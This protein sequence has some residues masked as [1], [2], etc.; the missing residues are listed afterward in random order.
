MEFPPHQNPQNPAIAAVAK[1]AGHVFS[2][3]AIETA[4]IC[5][6]ESTNPVTSS[7]FMTT[8]TSFF[9]P[10][11][12]QSGSGLKY[13]DPPS[14]HPPL[15]PCSSPF[16]ASFLPWDPFPGLEMPQPCLRPSIPSPT[17]SDIDNNCD[18]TPHNYSIEMVSV[19]V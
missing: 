3:K 16:T 7:S 6:S 19:P 1:W 5:A 13:W 4:D 18:P 8:C 17:D 10:I 11:S 9:G 2:A 14:S 12:L 15:S